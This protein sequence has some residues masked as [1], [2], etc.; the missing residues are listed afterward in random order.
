MPYHFED[1]ALDGE[2]R[3]LRRGNELVPVEPQVFD[4][5]QFLIRN[6]ERV[7][8]KDDLVDAVW[9]GRIVSD[10]TLASRVNAA[11][12]ALQDSGEEQRLVRTI[13]R[14]GFR[15]VGTVR[16]EG[17]PDDDGTGAASQSLTWAFPPVPPSPCCPSPI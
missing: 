14:R 2:R 15:F 16:E 6:R 1:F 12:N 9:Q 13:L 3:E 7:V 5:L 8:S 4:L 10:A 17:G 11:R